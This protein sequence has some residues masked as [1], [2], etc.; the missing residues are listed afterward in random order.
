MIKKISLW[1]IL[2][3]VGFFMIGNQVYASGEET[4][5]IEQTDA[6]YH[7]NLINNNGVNMLKSDRIL[8]DATYLEFNVFTHRD[9]A[10]EANDPDLEEI[11]VNE[12]GLETSRLTT[13][14]TSTS[15]SIIHDYPIDYI[16]EMTPELMILK[17]D[18]TTNYGVNIGQYYYSITLV[19]SD[20]LT[21]FDLDYILAVAN[22]DSDTLLSI[23]DDNHLELTLN[24]LDFQFLDVWLTNTPII[25]DS[26]HI[27]LLPE[28]SGSIYDDVNAMGDVS[29]L[30]INDYTVTFRIIYSQQAYD[31]TYTFTN[32]T[33][34]TLFDNTF[35]MF[36]YTDDD[37]HFIVFNQ[38]ETSMFYQTG[39]SQ[40]DTFIPYTTWNLDTNELASIERFNVYMYVR[41]GDGNHVFGY[42]YV[43]D[44][45]IDNLISVNAS[46]KYRF[47]PQ[48]YGDPTEW[49]DYQSVLEDGTYT[50][51]NLSWKV[52]ALDM[53]TFAAA[54]GSMIPGIRLP[55]A[56]IGTAVSAY[57]IYDMADDLMQG[58]SLWIGD[59]EEI[60]NYTPSASMENEINQAY[61]DAYPAFDGL[62]L[63]TYSLWQLDFG[64][65]EKSWNDLAIDE[66]SVNIIS[67]TYMTSGQVYTIDQEN[68]NT[69]VTIDDN[70]TPG[71]NTITSD[72][73]DTIKAFVSNL[74]QTNP[75][76]VLLLALIL[77]IIFVI[78]VGGLV[79]T[80]KKFKR[81]FKAFFSVFGLILTAII[82]IIIL[83][84]LGI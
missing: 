57:L 76:L 45:V 7:W 62:N 8:N 13:Y 31:L 3:F 75:E 27:S 56:L 18:T 53:S 73:W 21:S 37:S 54:F 47:E 16:D 69:Q 1:M 4:V 12:L 83:I 50:E 78:L 79:I 61:Q 39:L 74:Y 82:L 14:A 81:N 15:T 77:V 63:S 28:T 24:D 60:Q 58:N 36:Y 32:N 6:L 40:N 33:D 66:E 48:I 72:L 35:E 64:T 55:V 70:L 11:F 51:G 67:F 43:D 10:Y 41:L 38:G 25:V 65:F 80:L 68:I 22:N 42:F 2:L 23:I 26:D 5:T 19:L 52:K 17:D 20:T 59:T 49:Y 29:I 71:D 46:F 34:M 9:L 30:S 44:F 84:I